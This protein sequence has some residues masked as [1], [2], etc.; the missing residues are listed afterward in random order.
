MMNEN[1]LLNQIIPQLK[2]ENN[3]ASLFEVIVN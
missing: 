3:K 1:R 2:I